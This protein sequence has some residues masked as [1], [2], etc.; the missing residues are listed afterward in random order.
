MPAAAEL[1]LTGLEVP[2]DLGG[3]GL[4]FLGKLAVIDI[5]SE[6]AMGF[7]FSVVNT[8]SVAARIARE[9]TA[10]Q[11]DRYLADRIAAPASPPEGSDSSTTRP[12]RPTSSTPPGKPS[13][14]PLGRS[15]ALAPMWLPC[16]APWFAMA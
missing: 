7:A 4:D 2:E 1:G 6:T 16:A 8:A 3:L 13:R 14:L 11:Q 9:G 12:A 10:E 15:T 5:L